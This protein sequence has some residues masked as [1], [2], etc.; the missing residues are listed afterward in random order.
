M[1]FFVVVVVCVCFCVCLKVVFFCLVFEL[2]RPLNVTT[3]MSKMSN[4]VNAQTGRGRY[5]ERE[6]ENEMKTNP[7]RTSTLRGTRMMQD[8]LN[9]APVTAWLSMWLGNLFEAKNYH[10]HRLSDIHLIFYLSKTNS[11]TPNGSLS[12]NKVAK[13]TPPSRSLSANL[14]LENDPAMWGPAKGE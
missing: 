3:R 14:A 9:I 4:K 2:L 7:D 1:G 10:G 6:R 11:P 5:T 12:S 13:N 8:R